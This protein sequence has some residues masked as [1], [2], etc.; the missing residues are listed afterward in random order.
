LLRAGRVL[1]FVTMFAPKDSGCFGNVRVLEQ[2]AFLRRWALRLGGC[3]LLG[4]LAFGSYRGYGVWQR[5]HLQKQAQE[6]LRGNDLKSSVL[7]AR[8]LL[9]IDPQNVVAA[10]LM[11]EAA[12]KAGS[13]EAVSWRK[14]VAT[15]GSKSAEDQMALATSALRF[16]QIDLAQ[17]ASENI[18]QP[19]QNTAQFHV[20]RGTLALAEK[21]PQLAESHF[22]AAHDL[23]P[24]NDQ[25][26]LNLATVRLAASDPTQIANGQAD[27][28]RLLEHP[29]IRPEALRAL[30][31]AALARKE[32]EQAQRWA[33]QLRQEQ[34]STLS[35]WLLYLEA[36]QSTEKASQALE[37]VK[38]KAATSPGTVAEVVTW[39]NRHGQARAALDWTSSLPASLTSVQP[40]PLALAESYS[41]LQDWNS[42]RGWVEGKN[43]GVYESLRLAV[44]SHAL[45]RLSKLDRPSMESAT[46]WQAAL[47]AA[48]G[49]PGQVAA[50]AQL[51]EGWGY[52]TE[53]EEAWWIIAQSNENSMAAL[54]ALQRIYKAQKNSRGLLKVAQRALELNPADLVAANNYASLG[55]LLTGD[56]TARRLAAKLHAEHPAN[57]VFTG[58]YAFSLHT[59]GKTAE[60]L[61]VMESLKEETLRHPAIAAYY[62]IILVENGNMERAHAFLAAANQATLL[63]EEQQLLAAAIHKLLVDDSQKA[64]KSVAAADH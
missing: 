17:Q 22:A 57:S 29:S 19:A 5:F 34:R 35:D 14:M 26:A 63:P 7:V 37:E 24:A 15:L 64:A 41:F 46:A 52:Q 50:I 45:H 53:A 48:Q 31:T 58:T 16:G 6:F 44:L 55:L 3:L 42:L 59:E 38:A 43:W 2:R 25:T 13:P 23:D 60:A 27:L 49:R 47:K 62:F 9:Q 1:F 40:V 32:P 39:M 61:K 18:P 4:V 10:R 11:A 33:G 51:A 30:T 36:V 28:V 20:L 56:G 54:D 8:H 21:Q 12:E